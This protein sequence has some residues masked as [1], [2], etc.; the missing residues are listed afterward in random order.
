MIKITITEIDDESR[1]E[2]D[3]FTINLKD[4]PKYLTLSF[5]IALTEFM[6]NYEQEIPSKLSK[7]RL[8]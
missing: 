5:T 2:H 3:T 6:K 1:V 8:V 4:D 7:S